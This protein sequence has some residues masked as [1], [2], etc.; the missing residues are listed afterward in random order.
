MNAGE[1]EAADSPVRRVPSPLLGLS[2]NQ[3]ENR[4]DEDLADLA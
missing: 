1:S 2:Q 3:A 4:F